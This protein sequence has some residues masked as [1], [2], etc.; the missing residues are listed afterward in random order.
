MDDARRLIDQPA[1]VVL[2]S[3][4]ATLTAIS[5]DIILPATG[6][7][8]RD[9]GV[10]E[11]FA[12][13]TIGAYLIGYGVGQLG[14]GLISDAYGRKPALT[15]SLIGFS[16]ATIG[17]AFAPGF[18]WLV[19]LRLVQG[20]MA[21][22]PV[23]ARAICRDIASGPVLARLMSVQMAVTSI[24]PLI[25][26][27]VGAFLLTWV[28]WRACFA[29]LL[30]LSLSLLVMWL[31]HGQET[32]PKLRPERMSLGFLRHG[33]RV[34]FGARAFLVGVCASGFCFAGYAS[35]LSSGAVVVEEAYGLGPTA[36]GP[37]FAVAAVFL[38]IGILTL[39]HL[40]ARIGMERLGQVLLVCVSIAVAIQMVFW[41]TTPPLW[42]F[43]AGVSVYVYAL[44]MA[45]PWGQAY[46]META[47]DMPGFAASVLGCL[48]MLCG[49]FGA[50]I[51]VGLHDGSHR[52][53]SGTMVICG[54][55]TV[56]AL[57]R[58]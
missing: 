36:F 35:L 39:R 11:R 33:L 45:L 30:A 48:L 51:A 28:D 9:F 41:I 44:G 24:A 53:I 32:V 16:L 22:A 38:L 6:A 3:G 19:V 17:C 13:L 18:W 20:A 37:L 46:A 47:G 10:D 23:M 43:W 49:A 7:I 27:I 40:V 15:Y 34:L 54:V 25:A 55:L 42:L 21:G 12:A 52:A 26:P 4:L 31:R 5:I 14:W 8:A 29:V 1:F 56:L 2:L 58:R 57:L 50:A